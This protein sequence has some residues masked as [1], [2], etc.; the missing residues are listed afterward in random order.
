MSIP[1]RELSKED[2]AELILL[3]ENMWRG[4]TRFDRTFQEARFAPDF[5]EF[6]GS[7]LIHNRQQVMKT[8]TAQRI[9]AVLP[10]PDLS[11]RLLGEDVAQI[12]YNSHVTRDGVVH[13][14][15]RSS[16]W[17]RT[18]GGRW[19]MRFHQGTPYVP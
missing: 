18:T 12:T 10:L 4:D 17:S 13:Y 2:R 1:T 14:A 9:D 15:R 3:E 16:I 19:V 7:G 5:V 6:G 8:G 11:I